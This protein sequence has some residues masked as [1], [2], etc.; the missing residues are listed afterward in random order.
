MTTKGGRDFFRH[1]Q[2]ILRERIL[3]VILELRR[4]RRTGCLALGPDDPLDAVDHPLAHAHVVG[5]QID[6]EHRAV[7]DDIA[8]GAGHTAAY[9]Q[10]RKLAR[11]RLPRHNRLEAKHNKCGQHHGST[12]LC[13]IE[14]C[15]PLPCSVMRM[16]SPA[17]RTGPT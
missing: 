5:S 10:D 15:D 16:L 7:R 13:G 4:A 11:L 2:I 1:F 9:S 12:L 17:E 3:I 8:L 14:P 6:Q